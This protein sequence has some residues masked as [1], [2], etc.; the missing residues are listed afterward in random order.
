MYTSK[1][2]DET[3]GWNVTLTLS[4]H[5]V[6][7]GNPEIKHRLLGLGSL[8][9]GDQLHELADVGGRRNST[10]GHGLTGHVDQVSG[11]R[12]EDRVTRDREQVSV[13]VMRHLLADKALPASDLVGADAE[14][15]VEHHGIRVVVIE[16]VAVDVE[17]DAAEQAL[18]DVLGVAHVVGG[19]RAGLHRLASDVDILVRVLGVGGRWR[20]QRRGDEARRAVQGRSSSELIIRAD[21]VGERRDHAKSG[22]CSL[23]NNVDDHVREEITELRDREGDSRSEVGR[24]S[25][26]ADLVVLVADG[27]ER[28]EVSIHEQQ[29]RTLDIDESRGRIGVAGLSTHAH[30]VLEALIQQL[31]G[32]DE[33]IG[34]AVVSNKLEDSTGGHVAW[35]VGYTIALQ[36][37]GNKII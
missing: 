33:T 2:F 20:R 9:A 23:Q 34:L 1:S 5:L 3:S 35:S 32:H 36:I 11:G 19:R 31:S 16:R 18:T 24:A 12:R 10:T 17:L 28:L 37:I 29:M 25:I 30:D 21:V 27:G 22:A 4:P 15:A 8:R 14:L 6:V 26:R 7:K 13:G